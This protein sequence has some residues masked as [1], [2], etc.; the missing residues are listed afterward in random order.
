MGRAK[1]WPGSCTIARSNSKFRHVTCASGRFE[2]VSNPSLASRE[3]LKAFTL[4][5]RHLGDGWKKQ[6]TGYRKWSSFATCLFRT[7]LIRVFELVSRV[8]QRVNFPG[9]D[10]SWETLLFLEQRC[11]LL[12]WLKWCFLSLLTAFLSE[13]CFDAFVRRT[14]RNFSKEPFY[15]VRKG[16]NTNFILLSFISALSL[17]LEIAIVKL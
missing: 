5:Q 6:S 2:K 8:T 3:R 15:F 14:D 16:C 4:F 9:E 1:V 7:R 17:L 10:C 13:W 11:S 12:G